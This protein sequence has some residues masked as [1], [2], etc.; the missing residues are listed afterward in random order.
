M[1]SGRKKPR[2]PGWN[3]MVRSRKR[4]G[5]GARNPAVSPADANVPGWRSGSNLLLES[6]NAPGI[7]S[8]P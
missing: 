6:E 2:D 4:A 5:Y 8:T 7:G 1:E 3:W